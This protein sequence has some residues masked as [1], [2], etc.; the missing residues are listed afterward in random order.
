MVDFETISST[1]REPGSKGVARRLRRDGFVPGIIYGNSETPIAM[2]V[3]RRV[4]SQVISDPRF[5]IRLVDVEIDGTKHRVLPREVQFHPVSDQP[6]HVDFL[7]FDPDRK[8]AV[9]VPVGFENDRESIG[10]KRGGILNVVRHEVEVYCT[11]DRIPSDLSVD[12]EGLDIGD[13]VRASDISLPEG[14]GFVITDR[15]FTVATIAP[16]TVLAETTEEE[17]DEDAVAAEDEAGAE[18]ASEAAGG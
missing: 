12:I 10:I 13:S 17:T 4:L 18:D 2:A 14:I 6:I 16:P 1:R 9:A 5:F 7:R 3:E 11:A 8:I 15:D